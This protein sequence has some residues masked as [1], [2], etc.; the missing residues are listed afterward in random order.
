MPRRTKYGSPAADTIRVRVT[1]VQRIDLVQVA[2][3]NR[4]RVYD[5]IRDAVD[6]YVADYRER[7]VFRGTSA[8]Q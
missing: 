1:R 5:V 8:G 2:K 6:Q 4:V 7:L 3:D